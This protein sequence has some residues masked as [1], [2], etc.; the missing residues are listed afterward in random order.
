MVLSGSVDFKGF[1]FLLVE[2][3]RTLVCC[4]RFFLI[5]SWLCVVIC[6][7]AD[8]TVLLKCGVLLNVELAIWFCCFIV[9]QCGVLKYFQ[10]I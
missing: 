10:N 7:S 8:P 2:I 5:G 6:A 4:L 1:F 9:V 3:G